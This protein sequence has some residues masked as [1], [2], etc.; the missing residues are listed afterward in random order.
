MTK[1]LISVV[2]H[3]YNNQEVLN[4]QTNAW[5]EWSDIKE[6]ELIFIDDG[7]NPRLDTTK[8]PNWV[9]KFRV[10]ED[11]PWNQPGAKNLASHVST[12]EWLF[13][14]DADQLLQRDQ[15]IALIKTTNQLKSGTIYRL[16]R[17]CS[18]S[19][20][21]LSSHQNCQLIS[22]KDYL[23][24]GGYDE[25]F[26]GNYGHEDAYFERLWK[27]KGGGIVLLDQPYLQDHSEYETKNLNR[28]SRPNELLR[29]KKIRYWHIK[30]NPIGSIFLSI[31]ILFALLIK[32]KLIA[33]GAPSKQLRFR[34]EQI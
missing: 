6:L 2:I 19:K 30:K 7:S 12:G 11:I 33:N 23:S 18:K 27:F 17:F 5:Q 26:A 14:L 32:I 20:K 3:I 4:L 10:I 24:F 25:D 8:V 15:I 28:N 16:R 13:F 29:R 34:W 9:K 1:K 21:E 31:P 22:R